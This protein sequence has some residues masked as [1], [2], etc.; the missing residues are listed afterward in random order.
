MN[1]QQFALIELI[2]N[3]GVVHQ[4]NSVI[5]QSQ[6]PIATIA[7]D[8]LTRNYLSQQWK[9]YYEQDEDQDSFEN[10]TC[11][12][13]N[14]NKSIVYM[15]VDNR[16]FSYWYIHINLA[17]PT[18]NLIEEYVIPLEAKPNVLIELTTGKTVEL[19]KS[20]IKKLLVDGQ[21]HQL[22]LT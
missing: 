21:V 18:I 6:L 20:E 8:F 1:Q 2:D 5:N 7:S 19:H 4:R 17:V 15:E 10:R 11:I 12:L 13:E 14:E 16:K 22:T 9:L 3:N